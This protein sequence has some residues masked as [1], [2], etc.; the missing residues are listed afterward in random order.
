MNLDS[1]HPR[2]SYPK[3]PL[4]LAELTLTDGKCNTLGFYQPIE[5]RWKAK[6]EVLQL[7]MLSPVQTGEAWKLKGRSRFR[8]PE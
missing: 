3:K 6:N 1:M 2:A 8:E 7:R 4:R 5:G